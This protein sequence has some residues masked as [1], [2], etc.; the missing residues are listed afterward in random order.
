MQLIIGSQAAGRTPV[1]PASFSRRNGDPTAYQP[2]ITNPN[3]IALQEASAIADRKTTVSIYIL[4]RCLIEIIGQTTLDALTPAMADKL[5]DIV[6]LQIRDS[7]PREL[8]SSP[9]RL[10]NWTVLAELLGVMGNI[11]FMKVTDRFFIELE[12]SQD[13]K[14][15]T[16]EMEGRIE[17]VIRAFGYL[18]LK[19]SI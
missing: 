1:Q 9:L 2:P 6:F 10:S 11:N 5:Q 13:A 12:E 19:V 15:M 3:I 4:C 14:N 17:Y 7:D 18:Q 8:M 16:P